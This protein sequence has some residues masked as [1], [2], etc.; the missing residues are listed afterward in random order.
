M[1]VISDIF[2]STYMAFYASSKMRW[3]DS[4]GQGTPK[5]WIFGKFRIFYF[6][7]AGE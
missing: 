6:D 2:P 5:I 7:S 4:N 1:L 3:R